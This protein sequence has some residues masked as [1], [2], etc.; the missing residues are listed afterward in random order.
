L[1]KSAPKIGTKQNHTG[2]V[3]KMPKIC[4]LY[5]SKQI[6]P[7]KA[8]MPWQIAAEKQFLHLSGQGYV[9]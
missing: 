4:P 5:A 1:P 9:V 6:T 8:Q 7:P 3:K 2:F